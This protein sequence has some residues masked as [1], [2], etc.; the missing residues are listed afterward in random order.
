MSGHAGI[1]GA[2][3]QPRAELSGQPEPRPQPTHPPRGAQ[4]AQRKRPAQ[5]EQPAQSGQPA[6]PGQPAQREQPAQPEQMALLVGRR[7]R[8][9]SRRPVAEHLPVARVALM[10]PVPHLDRPFDYE[11]PAALAESAQPGVRVRVRLAGRLVDGFVLE[12]MASSDR[13][14][15]PI[16]SVHGPAV[17]TPQV[18]A[19]CRAVADRYAGVFADVVRFAVPP[20]HARAETQFPG[21]AAVVPAAFPPAAFP[22]AAFP[23]APTTPAATFSG[24]PSTGWG[25][26]RGG[27][28]LL[29]ALAA[30]GS[31]RALWVSAPAERHSDRIAELVAAAARSGGGTIVVVP[32]G[33]EVARVAESLRAALG[34]APLT[35]LAE[36]GPQARYR[37]F[38]SVL[39][40][41]E[42]VVVGTRSAVFA[43]VVDLRLVVVWDDG[44]ESLAEPQAPGWHAREVAALRARAD[45]V[46]LVVG[47]PSVSLESA[48]MAE[49]RMAKSGW[50]TPVELD[51]PQL[52]ATMP[53]VQVAADLAHGDPARTA[54][55]IPPVALE[56]L[57]AGVQRGPVLVH[58]PRAGYLPGLVCQSCREPVRCPE[59]SAQ[60][61]ADASDRRPVCPTHGTIR[62]WCCPFCGGG[63][64]RATVIGVR[65]TAEEFGRALP[66]A[67]V[68]T[69]SGESPI[70][71][72]LPAHCVVVATPGAAPDPGPQGYA[73][74]V[75]LDVAA[76]LS[77]PGLRVAEEVLRRWFLA[78]AQVRS[79]AA[80]GRVL[81][82]GE[83][84]IREVQAL[85]RWDPRG[86]AEREL[87]ERRQLRL[88]PAVRVA[89]LSG[90]ASQC[91]ALADEIEAALGDRVLRR[92]GPMPDA[93]SGL[94]LLS[95]GGLSEA[96][97]PEVPSRGP[98]LPDPLPG[99][100]LSDPLPGSPSGAA[101]RG[102]T[103]A[104]RSITAQ[105]MTTR[106]IPSSSTTAPSMPAP[107][108][109][110]S[111]TIAGPTTAGPTP[112]QSTTASVLL[113]VSMS[114]GPALTAALQRAQ[115][116]RSARH[117]PLV[118]VR[119]DPVRSLP[120][121]SPRA[122]SRLGQ[123][124]STRG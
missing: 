14:L 55:R 112:A 12:R 5:P 29:A 18:A 7:P 1:G 101:A 80:G 119:V 122:R 95:N 96:T 116:A 71:S 103:D 26:Y 75:V 121:R 115:A 9:K 51:R 113:A 89:A 68:L 92:S 43:P 118:T 82:V 50:L 45:D 106:S 17:L 13:P 47:G 79:A 39:S 73:A 99:G 48:R 46:A 25:R 67:P 97:L 41:A 117:A 49:S 110:A 42:R 31:P 16:R 28:E 98:L 104:G 77:R 21:V 63:Q 100:P 19:L 37:A 30:G 84:G 81:V 20:R 102:G 15:Q 58:V 22:P 69:A 34:R 90:P 33:G 91:A 8:A 3:E 78:A 124:P 111:S 10:S 109:T 88:P 27:T 6:Q 72:P 114:D 35:L 105:S 2:G 120:A 94:G 59:C 74:L 23:P 53:R 107:S 83:P 44:D 85:V 87:A 66:G 108:T 64:V 52:R 93:P 60:A 54:A 70:G 57:R 56:V 86:Y 38:L 24:P 61:S 62:D 76:A 11:V 123:Q 32:D 4:P 40:G 36:A 65:R